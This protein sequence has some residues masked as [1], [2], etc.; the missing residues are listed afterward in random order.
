M[1]ALLYGRCGNEDEQVIGSC[2]LRPRRA[3]GRGLVKGL[4]DLDGLAYAP[5]QRLGGLGQRHALLPRD[6][7][8]PGP[9]KHRQYVRRVQTHPRSSLA[10]HPRIGIEVLLLVAKGCSCHRTYGIHGPLQA[11]RV[12]QAIR[13]HKWLWAPSNQRLTRRS[14]CPRDDDL[15]MLHA[16]NARM[17]YILARSLGPMKRGTRPAPYA[18]D[19]KLWA[20]AHYFRGQR[21]KHPYFCLNCL[22]RDS[23]MN[24]RLP[25]AREHATY[26]LFLVLALRSPRVSA[27]NA[28]TLEE[29]STT[30]T[31][32]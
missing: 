31:S 9:A 8:S 14:R 12:R 15:V 20:A 16:A 18:R 19:E 11:I 5:R 29:L 30:H 1:G 24:V 3:S 25:L 22:S 17:T 10:V 28:L 2:F 21:G 4:R 32:P 7:G 13:S 27:W 6:C 26:S 23:G